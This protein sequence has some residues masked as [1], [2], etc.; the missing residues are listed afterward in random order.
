MEEVKELQEKLQ[1]PAQLGHPLHPLHQPAPEEADGLFSPNVP[2]QLVHKKGASHVSHV[3]DIT[4]CDF[5]RSRESLD[6]PKTLAEEEGAGATAEDVL[7]EIPPFRVASY[8]FSVPGWTP[9][10]VDRSGKGQ[11][12][13]YL[14]ENIHGQEGRD[15][16]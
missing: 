11:C 8:M 2:R 1:Q 16:S 10:K 6:M 9:T 14:Y 7:P 4:D 13:V 12:P 15:D 5:L 3:S